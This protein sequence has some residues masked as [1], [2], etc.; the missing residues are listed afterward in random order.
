MQ[1]HFYRLASPF[2][3]PNNQVLDELLGSLV[4]YFR[5]D[6]YRDGI[7]VIQHA[8]WDLDGPRILSSSV[9]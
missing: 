5:A 8:M 4:W 3:N 7:D 1:P 6:S 2:S 9:S